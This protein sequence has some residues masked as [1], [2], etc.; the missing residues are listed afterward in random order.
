MIDGIFNVLKPPGMTSHDVVSAMRKILGMKKI[1]HGGTLD[2]MAAGVLPVFAGKATRLLEYAVE[3]HKIYRAGITFGEKTDTGDGAGRV[4]ATSAVEH[5]SQEVLTKTLSGF[6]GKSQQIPP[7]YSALS[8]EGKKLYKLARD[9][10]VVDRKPR[11][12]YIYDL[13]QIAYKDTELLIEVECS[14]GT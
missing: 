8:Y 1:G 14:K 7:M 5:I 10:V 9:G 13:K 6:L 2:P 12:I 3:G 4:I 11:D